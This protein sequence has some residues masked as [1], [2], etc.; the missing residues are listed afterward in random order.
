MQAPHAVMI[1]DSITSGV[2]HRAYVDSSVITS[3][4]GQV[5]EWY[6]HQMT[7]HDLV[8]QN[9]G[10]GGQTSSQIAARFAAD[11]VALAPRYAFIQCGINDLSA[12]NQATYIANWTAML[13]ACAA[14]SVPIIPIVCLMTPNNNY[15]IASMRNRDAGTAALVSLC[16]SYPTVKIIDPN[17]YVSQFRVGG[18]AANLWDYQPDC[19]IGD[20]V[21]Q[22]LYG[23]YQYAKAIADKILQPESRRR[24]A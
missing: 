9:M 14:A 7:G 12:W 17:P 15:T 13:N 20:G 8:Y 19:D 3:K 18:D 16:A 11:C 22:S 2:D 4:Q 23:H 10:F 1:G 21:H 5:W 24:A 6:L